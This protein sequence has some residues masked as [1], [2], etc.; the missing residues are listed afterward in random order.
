MVV[1]IWGP[2]KIP[3]LARSLGRARREFEDASRGLSDGAS[4]NRLEERSSDSLVEIA[5]RLGI[6][7][8]GKTRQQISDE[9]VRSAQR[10]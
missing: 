3:D 1:L 6:S 9:I 5:Q 7:T 10:N 2:Q 8:K 4:S